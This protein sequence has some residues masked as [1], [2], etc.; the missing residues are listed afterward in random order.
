MRNYICAVDGI[1]PESTSQLSRGQVETV[2]SEG[3]PVAKSVLIVE[4]HPLV[5]SAT[6][7]LIAGCHPRGAAGCDTPIRPVVCANAREFHE[8]LGLHHDE[9]FRLFLDL[10]V[11]GAHGLSLVYEVHRR[12]LANRCCVI[13]ASERRDY[14]DE[15]A[16]LGFLGYICKAAPVAE[17]TAALARVFNGERYF[18]ETPPP[19]RPKALRLTHRQTELLEC[20]RVGWSSKQI[21]DELH[22][23]V[24]TVNNYVAA[25]LHLLDAESRAH[26]VAKAIELGLIAPMPVLARMSS[27]RDLR[28]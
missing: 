2:P 22:L 1:E 11:P 16:S 17:F 26:A 15:I 28:S 21:A 4:D 10:G 18:P 19:S 27:S 9:W 13:S 25:L 23:T 14:I 7:E 5:A 24:G 20:I 6:A 3:V 8:R 12:G